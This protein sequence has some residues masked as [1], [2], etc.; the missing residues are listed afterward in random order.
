MAEN[1]VKKMQPRRSPHTHAAF[2]YRRE[3]KRWGILLECGTGYL[4]F[5][6]DD[7]EA[8]AGKF[9]LEADVVGEI[10]Q[11]ATAHLFI[12]RMPYGGGTGYYCVRPRKEAVPPWVE[13]RDPEPLEGPPPPENLR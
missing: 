11:S 4:D 3:G 13:E 10:L 7:I 6:E 1:N 5:A 9:D 8:I 12:N 2:G